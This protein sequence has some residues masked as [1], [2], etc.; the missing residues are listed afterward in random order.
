M[1]INLSIVFLLAWIVL[2]LSAGTITGLQSYK[3]GKKSLSKVQEPKIKAD[4]STV[5]VVENENSAKIVDE[6]DILLQ[7]ESYIKIQKETKAVSNNGN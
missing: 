4:Q 6:N 5:L 2:I 7:V 3:L 1:K